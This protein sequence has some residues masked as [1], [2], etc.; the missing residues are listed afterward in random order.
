MKHWYSY[1]SEKTMGHTYGSTGRSAM[2]LTRAQK[3]L[4]VGDIIWVVEGN[5][6][7]PARFSL[8][9]CFKYDDAEFPPFAPSY[10]K[11]VIRILGYNSLLPSPVPLNRAD[12]WF[13]TL[14]GRFIT[15]QKFF[16]CLEEEPELVEGLCTASGIKF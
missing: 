3:K 16:S 4:E 14:H 12:K 15:K 5:I 2:Y 6:R 10:S 8:V 13:F 7:I 1:H 11:F 9:D